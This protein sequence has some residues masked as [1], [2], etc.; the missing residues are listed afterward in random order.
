MPSQQKLIERVIADL[1]K[2]GCT[3]RPGKGP[4]VIVYHPNGVDVFT[5]H[6]SPSD[7]RG[8]KNDRARINRSGLIWPDSILKV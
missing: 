5:I 1:V 7:H 6:T 4:T 2:Q 8:L 3:T